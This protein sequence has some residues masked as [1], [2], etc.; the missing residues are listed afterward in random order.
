MCGSVFFFFLNFFELFPDCFFLFFLQMR[1]E[2]IVSC[3]DLMCMSERCGCALFFVSAIFML[4]TT[5]SFKKKSSLQEKKG[6]H[7]RAY[8]FQSWQGGCG[9]RSMKNEFSDLHFSSLSKALAH[10]PTFLFFLFFF[11]AFRPQSEKREGEA[12]K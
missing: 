10:Q 2:L 12:G 8:S 6:K 5:D 3:W 1:R 4:I 9:F 7:G 11:G